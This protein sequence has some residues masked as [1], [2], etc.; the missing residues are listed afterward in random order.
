MRI[1][2]FISKR[3]SENLTW[4]F[5]KMVVEFHAQNCVDAK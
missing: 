3:E 4:K 1:R 5:D 2:I